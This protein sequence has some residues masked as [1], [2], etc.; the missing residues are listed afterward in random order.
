MRI[1]VLAGLLLLVS[2]VSLS[3]QLSKRENGTLK[4]SVT[5]IKNSKGEID[6][7]LFNKADGF[8]GDPTKVVQHVRGKI[9]NGTCSITF[10]NIPFG[11][12]AVSVYHDENNDKQMNKSWYG[13]PVEGV[14]VSNNAKGSITGPPSFEA[15]R[16]D[17]NA[18][19]NSLVIKMN[20]F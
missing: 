20:Y 12:Y 1:T 16:F 19:T 6:F 4:V 10:E 17:F 18:Q 8:P 2:L 7:N 14:A 3:F 11:K 9:N 5:D 13:K 15:A